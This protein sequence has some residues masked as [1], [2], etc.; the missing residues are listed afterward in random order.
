MGYHL[1]DPKYKSRDEPVNITGSD[2]RLAKATA[3]HE[4][5]DG[6]GGDFTPMRRRARGGGRI[7]DE[8]HAKD[9]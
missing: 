6:P 8:T 5:V 1:A 2:V 9:C 7:I 3:I 4:D